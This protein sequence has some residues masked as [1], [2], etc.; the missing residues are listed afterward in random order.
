MFP[1]NDS[2]WIIYTQDGLPI[3][4][5][6]N[7]ASPC[8]TDI[9]G[10][11]LNPAAYYYIDP[12]TEE[13]RDV[14]FR[15]RLND[16]PLKNVS[17]DFKEFVW[18]VFINFG[19]GLKYTFT[20]DTSGANYRLL[21]TNPFGVIIYNVPVVLGTN[22]RVIKA[23]TQFA[24]GKTPNDDY[25]LDFRAPLSAFEG[26][27][28]DTTVFSL[29]YFT[30]TQNLILIKDIICGDEINKGLQPEVMLKRK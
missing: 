28:F 26:F 25:F 17:G 22:V 8:S 16:T 12:I 4:A 30:S 27:N 10:D 18:G 9:V 1:I 21:I 23:T 19:S 15:M 5:V 6:P 7:N 13:E 24:C 2:L 3:T 11:L 20:I 14:C 29:C